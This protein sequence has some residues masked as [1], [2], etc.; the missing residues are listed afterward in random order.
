M[1]NILFDFCAFVDCILMQYI[2]GLV[3]LNECFFWPILGFFSR[4][5]FGALLVWMSYLC[6]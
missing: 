1:H 3:D 2:V 4:F 6:V 5:F